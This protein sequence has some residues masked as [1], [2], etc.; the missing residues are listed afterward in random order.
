MLIFIFLYITLNPKAGKINNGSGASAES[1][2]VRDVSKGGGGWE[3]PRKTS[4]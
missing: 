3:I 1:K 4:I 2:K